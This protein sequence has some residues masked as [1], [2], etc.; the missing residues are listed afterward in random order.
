LTFQTGGEIMPK[1]PLARYRQIWFVILSVLVL[2][3]SVIDIQ[4]ELN[5]TQTIRETIY[6]QA[7]ARHLA[8]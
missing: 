4:T 1:D 5:A 3:C 7:A 6:A 2:G 8:E